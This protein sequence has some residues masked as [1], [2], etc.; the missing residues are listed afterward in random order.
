VTP[1]RF[2]AIR[3]EAGLTQA[4]LAERLRISDL[5]TIRKW[6]AGERAVSGPVALLM[7]MLAEGRL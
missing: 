1:E 3:K 5:R 6:E 2:K 4:D 7:E